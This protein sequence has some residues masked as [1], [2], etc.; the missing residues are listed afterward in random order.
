MA[1]CAE[2]LEPEVLGEGAAGAVLGGLHT[3]SVLE[4]LSPSPGGRV[5]C[6]AGGGS[7]SWRRNEG[8]SFPKKP[9]RVIG[10]CEGV[11][12]GGCFLRLAFLWCQFSP[13]CIIE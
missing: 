4:S 9:V 2:F 13:G 11:C 6:W 1:R 8:Q 12:R 3:Q 5:P 7:E 10:G